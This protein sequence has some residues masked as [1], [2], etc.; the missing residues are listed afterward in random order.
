MYVCS[1]QSIKRILCLYVCI[2]SLSHLLILLTSTVI[3]FNGSHDIHRPDDENIVERALALLKLLVSPG[4]QT[5]PVMCLLNLFQM[6][7]ICRENFQRS[8]PLSDTYDS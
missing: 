4:T 1:S 3:A 5:C 6:Q 8:W 7:D 2:Q